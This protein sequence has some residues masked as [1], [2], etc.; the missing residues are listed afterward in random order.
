MLFN[1]RGYLQVSLG[2]GPQETTPHSSSTQAP[3]HILYAKGCKKTMYQRSGPVPTSEGHTGNRQLRH[4]HFGGG[5]AALYQD[6]WH[7]CRVNEANDHSIGFGQFAGPAAAKPVSAIKTMENW[8][9]ATHQRW[10][11]V[12]PALWAWESIGTTPLPIHIF[13]HN[14][15]VQHTFPF[16]PWFSHSRALGKIT[17][18]ALFGAIWFNQI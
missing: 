10:S 12:G 6:K 8:F 13:S 11:K 2:D 14:D 15:A 5:T 4:R 16:P 18:K 7:G 1:P 3:C 17:H 9:A